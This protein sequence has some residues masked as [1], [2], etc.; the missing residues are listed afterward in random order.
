MKRG[1]LTLAILGTVAG[2][3]GCQSMQRSNAGGPMMCVAPGQGE[4]PEVGR[5][6]VWRAT[7]SIEVQVVS[8]AAARAA[9]LTR[10]AGGYVEER[11]DSSDGSA[12]LTLRLPAAAL[13]PALTSLEEL[14][15]VTGRNVS[16]EDVTDRYVDADAR[17]RALVA[18]RDRLQGLLEKAQ[19]VQDILAIEKELGRI[20]GELESLQAR[21]QAL[22]GQ[23]DLATIQVHLSRRRILGPLGYLFK[24][25][26]W[27]VEKLFVLQE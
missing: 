5:M 23:V 26:W 1:L 4:T 24:G 20:Q 16:S 9:D 18:L 13:A 25:V 3:T 12:S 27:T 10:A 22:K 21:L 15:H 7:L 2:L 11:T 6:R 19:N 8:N 14:G 17:T